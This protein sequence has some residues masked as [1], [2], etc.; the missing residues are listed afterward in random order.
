MPYADLSCPFG[1][2]SRAATN[3]QSVPEPRDSA[4]AEALKGPYNLAQGIALSVVAL[5]VVAV[6]ASP[7]PGKMV[8]YV[9][10]GA[11]SL[12]EVGRADGGPGQVGAL[13]AALADGRQA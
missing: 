10:C 11:E 5:S 8:H 9:H 6:R 4:L 1:A 3:L 7:W 13:L 2:Y 12:G